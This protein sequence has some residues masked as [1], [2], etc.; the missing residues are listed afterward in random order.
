MAAV[1]C[2]TL[3]ARLHPRVRAWQD[4]AGP[5]P[6]RCGPRPRG[7]ACTPC[8]SRGRPAAQVEDPSKYGV[9]VTDDAGKVDRF[10]EK[11]KAR[12]RNSA[13]PPCAQ[14]RQPGSPVLAATHRWG[15]PRQPPELPALLL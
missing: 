12:A 3:E 6:W 7:C 10:V 9:V 8:A 15:V 4:A 2:A 1:R 5:A 13:A 14:H 11:P